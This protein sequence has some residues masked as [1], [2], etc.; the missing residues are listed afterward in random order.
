MILLR[1]IITS[2]L[3]A[4]YWFLLFILLID[5]AD[6]L[7]LKSDLLLVTVHEGESVSYDVQHKH[8]VSFSLIDHTPEP[9]DVENSNKLKSVYDLD[10]QHISL[11][12]D[13]KDHSFRFFHLILESSFHTINIFETIYLNNCTFLI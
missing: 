8:H 4:F 13:S 9:N 1:K 11:Y 12:T 3:K 5:V 10:S 6:L 7:S 2:Y